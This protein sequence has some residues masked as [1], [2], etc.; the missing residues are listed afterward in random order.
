MRLSELAEAL[1]VTPA[2]ASDAVSTLLRKD[3]IRKARSREDARALTLTLTARGRREASR[4]S[5]W[6]DFLLGAIDALTPAEQGIFLLALVKMVRALQ[7]QGK[8]LIAR[9]CVNC[10]FFERYR[11]ADPEKPHHCLFVDA[12]FGP[13]ELRL[14]CQDFEPALV[15]IQRANAVALSSD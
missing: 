12:P 3:L 8:I 1:A 10:R 11:Y 13:R 9:M 2:T 6:P 5:Q 14:D 15:S 7:D 4:T